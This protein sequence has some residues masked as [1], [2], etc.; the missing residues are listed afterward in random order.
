MLILTDVCSEGFHNCGPNET[1][2]TDS[3]TQSFSCSDGEFTSSLSSIPLEVF[4]SSAFYSSSLIEMASSM[5]LYS[6]VIIPTPNLLIDE[7]TVIVETSSSLFFSA[8]PTP[9]PSYSTLEQSTVHSET[10]QSKKGTEQPKVSSLTVGQVNSTVY[11]AYVTPSPTTLIGVPVEMCGSEICKPALSC[12]SYCECPTCVCQEGLAWT[13]NNSNPCVTFTAGLA[14]CMDD[15][16]IGISWPTVLPGSTITLPC[17]STGDE[18]ELFHFSL[19]NLC[20]S[21]LMRYA[22]YCFTLGTAKASRTCSLMGEWSN[23]SGEN[24]VSTSVYKLQAV[25]SE[26]IYCS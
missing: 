9:K 18:C 22:I 26:I 3:K 1:C 20:W 17:C 11:E 6:S 13:G 19:N 10:S 23:F 21:K 24:C 12:V 8:L 25:V 16:L 4:T 14:T 7:S 5:F 15:G 2:I